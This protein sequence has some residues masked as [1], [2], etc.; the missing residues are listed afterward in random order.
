VTPAARTHNTG[1]QRVVRQNGAKNAAAAP[2]LSDKLVNQ[3]IAD[4]VRMLDWGSEWPQLAGLIARLGG[5]PAEKDVWRI[6]R[7]H[8]STIEARAKT[9]AD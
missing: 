2:K 3:V 9:P 4:A 6:L 8:K 5:R 1:A 7:E